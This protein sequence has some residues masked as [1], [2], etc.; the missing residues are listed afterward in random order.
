MK[1]LLSVAISVVL[2]LTLAVTTVAYAQDDPTA[3]QDSDEDVGSADDSFDE[4][5]ATLRSMA[6][7]VIEATEPGSIDRAEGLRHIIRLVEMQNGGF[8][9]DADP[10]NPFVS[11]CGM[12]KLG[13]DNPDFTYLSVDPVS[14]DYEYRISGH[15]GS[16]PYITMQVFEGALGGEVAMTSEDLVVNDDGTFEI[17]LSPERPEDAQNWLALN[18]GARRF[19]LRQ[20]HSDWNNDVEASIQVEV[21]GG[22][23][24][25]PVPTLSDEKFAAD[26]TAMSDLL[27]LLLPIFQDAQ[28]AWPVNDMSVPEVGAFGIPGA[29][30]PTTVGSVGRFELAEDQAM[31]IEIS[32]HD[33]VHGGIQLG[34]RWLESL[35]YRTRQTSLNWHQSTADADGK[36]RYVLAHSDPGTANWLDI[37]GHPQGAVFTRWQDPDEANHPDTPVVSIVGLDEVTETLPTDH[38]TVIPAERN[39]VLELRDEGINRRRNPAG[40]TEA[41]SEAVLGAPTETDGADSTPAADTADEADEADGE[42]DDDG[43]GNAGLLALGA[44]PIAGAAG[45]FIGQ[46][47]RE[48]QAPP[49]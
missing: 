4:F 3:A 29:G 26:L 14:A 44:I 42:S 35:D 19:L 36:Y 33:V 47:R 27:A 21:I 8:T 49:T 10:A 37:S 32:D 48:V 20:A 22:P 2:G 38:P 11:R 45:W 34:N 23:D 31:I 1:S 13:L 12:C 7:I 25:A 18:E 43:L 24:V 41:E 40:I 9:D 28:Q 6:E 17:I 5:L 15:R 30:F 39:E 46:R 16:V